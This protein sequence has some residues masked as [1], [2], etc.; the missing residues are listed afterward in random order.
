[1]KFCIRT[2][3]PDVTPASS[4]MWVCLFFLLALVPLCLTSR[5]VAGDAPTVSN[6]LLGYDVHDEYSPYDGYYDWTRVA[7]A[8]P[9]ECFTGLDN[10]DTNLASFLARYPAGLSASAISTCQLLGNKPK[11]NQ[12]YVWGLT[13]VNKNIWFSTVANTLCLVADS[14][15]G[16]S[17]TIPPLQNSS[18][19]CEMG[20]HD[21]RPPRIFVY[22]SYNETLTD[23]TQKVLDYKGGQDKMR[24]LHTIGLRSAGNYRGVVFFGG[25]M[26]PTISAQ[27][28]TPVVLYAFE[29]STKRYLGSALFDG[30][31][32]PLYTNIRQWRVV[33][34]QLFTGVAT[35]GSGGKI[36]RWTGSTAAPFSFDTVGAIVGDPAYLVEHK[37]RLFVS[38]WGSGGKVY[39]MSLYM[40]PTLHGATGLDISDASKWK[41]VWNLANY[42]VE[43]TAIQ[44]GGALASYQGYLYWGTM[45]VPGTGLV[46][47]SNA[48]P[49]VTTIAEAA[50]GTYRPLSIFRGKQFDTNTPKVDLLYG[51]KLLPKY[52][53]AA[54]QWNLVP[55]NLKQT[56]KYGFFGFNNIFNNYTWS[57]EVYDD[58]LFVGTM[59][60][61]FL[62]TYGNEFIKNLPAGLQDAAKHFYGAD[63][64]QFPSSDDKAYP[65]SINGMKNYTNYGIRTMAVGADA[66]WLGMANPMNLRTDPANKQL[67]GWELIKLE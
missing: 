21:A 29:A 34:S 5:A 40:S 23:L 60:W 62:A 31:S 17:D 63:L 57:M 43:P 10:H 52:D 30:T 36:L 32:N 55:N 54:N 9:D 11:V 7:K 16:P 8:T 15:F 37:G 38:T 53:P 1:M 19:A 67:G 20:G 22:D 39:G 46:A 12:A 41:S 28:V 42:E 64:W 24:L 4:N 51:S 26:A 33:N 65:V 18:W 49:G 50:I 56:P 6:Y 47:F 14:F 3:T 48:Y 35:P 13:V 25:L 61:S 27:A 45:H 66:F 58:T 2:L 44:V 59:D